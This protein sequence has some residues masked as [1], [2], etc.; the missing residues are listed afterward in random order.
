[1]YKITEVLP[2]YVFTRIGKGAD[3]DAVDYKRRTYM[4]LSGQTVS[5]V[6]NL[7]VRAGSD[8]DV[9]FFQ[10]EVEETKTETE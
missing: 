8:N 3:V 6:Q 10:I 1:M 4:D 2:D 9:K 7:V 5:Y